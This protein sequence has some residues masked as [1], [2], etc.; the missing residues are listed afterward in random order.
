MSDFAADVDAM[1][2]RA[3]TRLDQIARFFVIEVAETAMRKTPGPDGAGYE[4][5]WPLTA[6]EAVGRLRDG[7]GWTTAPIGFSSKGL[8]SLAHRG[9]YPLYGE[10]AL[11]RIKA[12]LNV[13]MP[14]RGY[15]ENVIAYG[16]EIKF[17]LGNLHDIPKR[18]F[19]I[20]TADQANACFNR[21]LS[22][23]EA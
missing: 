13:R 16:H 12:A 6:Y 9:D 21:A 19:D 20:W 14:A 17:S 4:G 1:F 15:L 8:D 3:E 2:D 7:W 10:A 11:L 5:Q 18:P 22:R 23:S